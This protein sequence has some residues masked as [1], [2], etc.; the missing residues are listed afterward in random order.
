MQAA[1][2]KEKISEVYRIAEEIGSAFRIAK[3]TPDGHLVGAFGQIAAKLAF[4]LEFGADGEEHNCTW[5]DGRKKV[6]VQVRCTGA[7]AIALRREP[8]HLIALELA[9][10]GSFTL[11]YNGPGK[12]VWQRVQH[13][14]AV[15]KS[16]SRDA[17]LEL[18][19]TVPQAERLPLVQEGVL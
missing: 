13:Q 15:Q 7:G 17:L 4:G 18:D 10:S 1:D 14:K 5:S 12:K 19:R 11:L 6:E 16:I 9:R 8:V 2:F 3:C